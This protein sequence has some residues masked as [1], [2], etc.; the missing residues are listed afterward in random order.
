MP[1]AEPPRLALTSDGGDDV[2]E[3]EE[4]DGGV[5]IKFM[6]RAV[7][8]LTE[9]PLRFA[10]VG[11]NNEPVDILEQSGT[12]VKPLATVAFESEEQAEA[13]RQADIAGGQMLA[14]TAYD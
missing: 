8:N 2:E 9:L 4:E 6:P 1:L 13:Q 7:R 3:E 5:E 10:S 11:S 14:G 12:D